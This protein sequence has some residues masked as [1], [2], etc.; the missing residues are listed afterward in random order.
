MYAPLYKNESRC[1]PLLLLVDVWSTASCKIH[2][3]HSSGTDYRT[4]MDCS[5]VAVVE[6][7]FHN[8]HM[9]H[10]RLAVERPLERQLDQPREV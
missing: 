2:K 1:H 4:H 10:I 3:I 8:R 5:V 9:R 6:D 7:S